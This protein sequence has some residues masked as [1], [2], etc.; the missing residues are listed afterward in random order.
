MEIVVKN[1]V[2]IPVHHLRIHHRP[3]SWDMQSVCRDQLI[4]TPVFGLEMTVEPVWALY[5]LDRILIIYQSKMF[6][7]ST[8]AKIVIRFLHKFKDS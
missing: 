7:L 2:S 3:Q 1:S 4:V 5:K 6:L 8:F